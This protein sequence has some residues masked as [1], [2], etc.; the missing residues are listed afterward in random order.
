MSLILISWKRI[1][2]DIIDSTLNDCCRPIAQYPTISIELNKFELRVRKKSNNKSVNYESFKM[3]VTSRQS[4]VW[5]FN[6]SSFLLWKWKS[7]ELCL[8][9]SIRYLKNVKSAT[10]CVLWMFY[11]IF[12]KLKASEKS[13]VIFHSVAADHNQSTGELKPIF[14]IYTTPVIKQSNTAAKNK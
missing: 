1:N 3:K 8:I 13:K 11:E 12:I 5:T 9:N 10:L 6:P 2:L 14:E 4:F 7:V